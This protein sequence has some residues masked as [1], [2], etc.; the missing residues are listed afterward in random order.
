MGQ[1][2]A[3]FVDIAVPD[4]VLLDT[5]L[6]V[7]PRR[8][9]LEYGAVW[10]RAHH[11]SSV[12][13]D[14]TPEQGLGAVAYPVKPSETGACRHPDGGIAFTTAKNTGLVAE[15]ALSQTQAFT[16]AVRFD[17]RDGEARTLV[18]INPTDA[19]NYLFLNEKE[20]EL[21]WQDQKGSVAVAIPSPPTPAWVVV[22]YDAGRL[23]IAACQ[24]GQRLA[25]LVTSAA[26]NPKLSADLSGSS[27]LFI[28]CR[29]HRKGILKTLGTSRIMDVL[30]WSD[31][32]VLAPGA[33]TEL[34]AVCRYA[35]TEGAPE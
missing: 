9:P 30:L 35:E 31:S 1:G 33:A 21:T 16:C 11:A 5:K 6:A 26:Q 28:G 12:I 2:D 27:D 8:S 7:Q 3:Y 29:S 25:P 4:A 24:E 13:Q 18:T 14:W 17:S 10:Y 20:G 22:G 34:N 15:G 32:F 23:S 19:D